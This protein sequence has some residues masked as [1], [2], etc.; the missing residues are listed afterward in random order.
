MEPTIYLNFR[1]N[2]LEAMKH[3]AAVLGG[4][5]T[6]V[7]TNADAPDPAT[8]MPGGDSM[9]MNMNM[10]LGSA[11]VMASDVPETWYVKPQGFSVS[12]A[13]ASLQEFDRIYAALSE[14]AQAV[15]M[16]PAETF[17]AERFAM[18]TDRYGTPW[19]LNF[20]GSRMPG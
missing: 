14:D 1:G 16:A 6:G 8:R 12:I 4:E 18:F 17:W 20:A 7:F 15:S 5:I 2:C 19:M 11:N 13:P 10:R 3:Y 9:V